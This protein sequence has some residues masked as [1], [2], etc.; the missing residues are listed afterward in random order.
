MLTGE[1]LRNRIEASLAR[2]QLPEFASMYVVR[3]RGDLNAAMPNYM[4][5]FLEAQFD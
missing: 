1:M 4:T 5:A 3:D 2:Q